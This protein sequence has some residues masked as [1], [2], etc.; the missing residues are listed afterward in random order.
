MANN[1]K[2]N[3]TNEEMVVI[4]KNI[5]NKNKD[6]QQETY[7]LKKNGG[8]GATQWNRDPT[9]CPHCKREFYHAPDAYFELAKNKDT[10]LPG[11]KIWL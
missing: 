7:C 4:V 5:S 2:I 11:W 8:S 6:I 3:A 10:G 9:L 1:A